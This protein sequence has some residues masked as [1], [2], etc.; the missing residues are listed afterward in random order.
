VKNR[1]KTSNIAPKREK[2]R[3]TASFTLEC[4]NRTKTFNLSPKH[5][6][7]HQNMKY[8]TKMWKTE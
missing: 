7:M 6:E 3:Q 8:G 2:T 4:E 5:R 1:I